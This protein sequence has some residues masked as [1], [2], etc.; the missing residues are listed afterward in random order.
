[1]P[2]GRWQR[3]VFYMSVERNLGL[4]QRGV[5]F[6]WCESY[7]ARQGGQPIEQKYYVVEMSGGGVDPHH[8]EDL[9]V[10]YH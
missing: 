10:K 6:E 7:I 2:S 5:G 4:G 1:M 9:G 8:V 3:A